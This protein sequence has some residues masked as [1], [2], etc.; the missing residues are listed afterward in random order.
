MGSLSKQGLVGRGQDTGAVTISFI[1][2]L[3]RARST[4]NII[5]G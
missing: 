3:D 2:H 1:C 5:S 4:L